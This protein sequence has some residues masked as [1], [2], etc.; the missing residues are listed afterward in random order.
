MN[1][2]FLSVLLTATSIASFAQ[3]SPE[4][5]AKRE[6]HKNLVVKEW[7]KD[8]KG[9]NGWLDHLT[10]YDDQ[11]RKIEEIEYANYGMRERVVFFYE[12]SGNGKVTKE[13]VYDGRNKAYRIR[14]YEYNVDGTK[15][16]QYNYM[17]NGKLYS[18]KSFE[19]IFEDESK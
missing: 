14:K 17:P 7:N 18:M 11:G 9:R 2:L 10:T 5:I 1:K 8:S 15:K 19:Y 13:V 3:L 4:T 12:E 6:R 16:K